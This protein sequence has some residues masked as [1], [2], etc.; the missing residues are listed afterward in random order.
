M[1]VYLFV[2]SPPRP[3]ARNP[4]PP[5]PT[6]PR[7][8]GGA[9]AFVTEFSAEESRSAALGRLSLS[10]GAGMAVGAMGEAGCVCG[11]EIE[12]GWVWERERRGVC[13][14]G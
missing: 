11:G 4:T 12:A 9:Q 8:R 7:A 13:G 1:S 6:P 3:N 5:S 2:S 10:Y 14:S